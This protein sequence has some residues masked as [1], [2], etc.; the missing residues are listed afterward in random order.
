LLNRGYVS[1][2]EKKKKYVTQ[3]SFFFTQQRAILFHSVDS[4]RKETNI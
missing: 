2:K 1:E 4:I 3:F